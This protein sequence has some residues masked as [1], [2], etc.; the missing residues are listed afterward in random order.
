MRV[1]SPAQEDYLLRM[2]REAAE[3]LRRLREM[4]TGS[5]QSSAAVRAELAN[6]MGRLLGPDASLLQRLDVATA[7]RLLNDRRRLE[8][9]IGA[10]ELEADALTASGSPE[11]VVVRSRAGALREA[12]VRLERSDSE[13]TSKP[14]LLSS[15]RVFD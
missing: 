7:V 13:G 10:L 9:W 5:A 14:R 1:R 11:A 3:A 2:I 8:L 12:G 15:D 4:L 6:T